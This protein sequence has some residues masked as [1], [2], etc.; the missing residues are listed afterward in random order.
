MYDAAC[1]YSEMNHPADAVNYLWLSFEK[2]KRVF[3][4][5]EHDTYLDNIRNTPEF[6]ALIE[7]WKM[8]AT[9]LSLQENPDTD[10]EPV[11][12]QKYIVKSK[13]L[14][15]GVYEVPCTVNDL[16]LNF[17]FDTGASDITISSLEAAF[18]LKNN[19]L[20]EYDFKDRRNYRTAS[21]DIVEGTII[22]LR[23]IKIGELELNNIEA[24]VVHRQN[25]PL[26]L[27][28]S[29]LGKFVK[30]TIDNKNNEII[31]EK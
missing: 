13:E 20:T 28:Q 11:E 27:G 2:G 24:S 9:D 3:T 22:R 16:P 12:T 21:G 19:Y 26:L 7:V 18:M 15:G 30:I 6:I 8:K 17:I 4:H 25:A 31:F 5:I 29:A 1:L 23:K 14:R 10:A